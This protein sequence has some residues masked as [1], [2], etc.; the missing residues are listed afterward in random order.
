MLLITMKKKAM[1]KQISAV[2]KYLENHSLTPHITRSNNSMLIGIVQDTDSLLIAELGDLPGV[3]S[4]GVVKKA[5][6]LASRDFKNDKTIVTV[7]GVEIGGDEIVVIA[8]PCAVESREQLLETAY[9]VRDGGARFLRGGAYKPR[10]S[11]YS[12]QGLG[13]KGL[14]L[15]AEAREK[16]NLGIVTEVVSPA[17]IDIV[18][19]TADI[20]QVGARNMQNFALLDA[21]GKMRKP[22]LL[23]RGMMSTIEELLMSA[24]YLLASGNDQVILCERGI[25]TFEKYTRNTLDFAIVPLVH[26]LSHLPIILDPS[27]AAGDRELVPP[28]AASALAAGADG[29]I[30]EVHIDPDNALCDGLQSLRAEE[31]STLMH[32]FRKIARAMGRDIFEASDDLS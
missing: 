20:L 27:H 14:D 3:E 1:V 21:L 10:S 29:L 24:E 11:P 12:F 7:R 26:R 19:R 30:I 28:L 22:V 31:F 6:K 23:K 9:R 5:F 16:T 32:H 8:G 4:V 18:A 25:R 13:E 17:Q 15:L 2:I